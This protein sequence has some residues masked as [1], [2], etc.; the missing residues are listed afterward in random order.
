MYI[1]TP[2]CKDVLGCRSCVTFVAIPGLLK[3]F[4]GD[5]QGV[6]RGGGLPQLLQLW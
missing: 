3:G 1:W 4:W 2:A 6:R 5:K